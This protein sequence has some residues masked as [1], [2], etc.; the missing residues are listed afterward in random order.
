MIDGL[1]EDR[2]QSFLELVSRMGNI[3]RVATILQ[4]RDLTTMLSC[5]ESD[6]RRPPALSKLSAIMKLV[7]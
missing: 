5:W 7:W 4:H 6:Y 1:Q 2:E 3:K